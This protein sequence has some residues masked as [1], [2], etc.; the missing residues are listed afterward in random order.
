MWY[1][2]RL[3]GRT[4][5]ASGFILHARNSLDR[6]GFCWTGTGSFKLYRPAG[7][8]GGNVNRK[9]INRKLEELVREDMM[10]AKASKWIILFVICLMLKLRR[11]MQWLAR[12][13]LVFLC[14]WRQ[15]QGWQFDSST[16]RY[17]VE[18]VLL[19]QESI[20]KWCGS[21]MYCLQSSHGCGSRI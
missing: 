14:W 11:N 21:M 15:R 7:V 2:A 8:D 1:L 4:D 3:F 16:V 10:N 18:N 6:G 9:R 5:W 13:F 12:W 17:W 20:S 19:V